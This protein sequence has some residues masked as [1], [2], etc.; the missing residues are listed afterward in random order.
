MNVLV[1]S[2]Q[3]LPSFSAVETFIVTLASG[4]VER[5]E[6]GADSV[7]VMTSMPAGGFD[8]TTLPFRVVRQPSLHTILYLTQWADIV[9]LTDGNMRVLAS[10]LWQR[11]PVVLKH[12]GY[13][14]VCQTGMLYYLPGRHI[15]PGHFQAR[16]YHCCI[17]CHSER[18]GWQRSVRYLFGVMVRRWLCKRFVTA[19]VAITEHVKQRIQL[20]R[21]QV[22]YYGVPDPYADTDKEPPV[23]DLETDMCFAYVG[24]F[25]PEKGL[26]M[27][28]EALATLRAEGQKVRLKFVGAGSERAI[29]E[30][31]TQAK[32]L[33]D[34]VEFTG[35]LRGEQL[36]QALE[37]VAVV[38]MPSLWEETAGMAALEHMMR[39]RPI[40]A[41][42]VGGLGEITRGAGLQFAVGDIAGL[43]DCMRQF[44]NEPQFVRTLG[45]AARER[46]R[47]LFEREH[48]VDTYLALYQ[49][50]L[51]GTESQ[52]R[53]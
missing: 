25:M 1:Y 29:L 15:C 49:Q 48:M 46:A 5:L 22:I 18:V 38:V 30:Q 37:D 11:K 45:Q 27:L 16:R 19:N 41:S 40:I 31:L 32:H 23:P 34:H 13:N 26:P 21:S 53:H 47:A 33:Q 36:S 8:D 9:Q 51:T 42:A 14:T 6:K 3:F 35:Y 43:T 4:L 10:A 12:H 24:R 2:Y 7:I 17:H 20:P 52:D 44:L 50:V 28:I 39:G